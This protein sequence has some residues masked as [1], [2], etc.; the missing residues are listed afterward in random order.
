MNFKNNND[1]FEVKNDFDLMPKLSKRELQILKMHCAD[2]SRL[3][4]ALKLNISVRTVDTHLVNA[5]KKYELDT[6]SQLKSMFIFKFLNVN[7]E[8]N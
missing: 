2:F 8:L 4:I 3:D 6:F 7:R 1:Q 5:T